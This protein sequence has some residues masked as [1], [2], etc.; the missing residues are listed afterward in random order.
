MKTQL[1]FVGNIVTGS[2]FRSQTAAWVVTNVT[3]SGSEQQISYLIKQVGVLKP[4]CDLMSSKDARCCCI[5]VILSGLNNLFALA[6]KRGFLDK[7]ASV[8]EGIGALE[9]LGQLQEHKS[10]EV[11]SQTLI[12]IE[13]YFNEVPLSF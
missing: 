2:E 7:F 9:T 6:D 8:F 13:T 1:R 10:K 4:F 5:L 11:W 12:L 3:S